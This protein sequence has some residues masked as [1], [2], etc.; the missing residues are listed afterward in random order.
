MEVEKQSKVVTKSAKNARAICLWVALLLILIGITT[1]LICL[2]PSKG[3]STE[4]NTTETSTPTP[5]ITTDDPSTT[6]KPETEPESS[7]WQQFWDVIAS[8]HF[9]WD[10][11][12]LAGPP[13]APE[14][15]MPY[16]RPSEAGIGGVGAAFRDVVTKGATGLAEGTADSFSLTGIFRA[17]FVF[18]LSLIIIAGITALIVLNR[19][20]ICKMV[21]KMK[22]KFCKSTSNAAEVI[23]DKI[24]EPAL[25]AAGS[26]IS[27]VRTRSMQSLHNIFSNKK[28]AIEAAKANQDPELGTVHDD[29]EKHVS[30]AAEVQ[31]A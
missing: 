31:E 11:E 17:V 19:N 14:T 23:V 4:A 26:Q 28:Q 7:W 29:G 18:C 24:V 22:A 30:F 27:L 25:R 16:V 9:T 3:L 13:L 1:V 12:V 5:D 15:P 10:A 2:N 21:K 6:A 20:D 8:K